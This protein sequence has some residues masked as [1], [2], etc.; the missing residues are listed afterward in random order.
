MTT[1]YP[2]V[3]P[4]TQPF[5]FSPTLDGDIFTA[6]VTWSLFGRRFYLNVYAADGTLIF[7]LPLIGSPSGVA[8]QSASFDHGR[9]T[10][11]TASPHGY[12]L[13]DTINL[14]ISGTTPDEYNGTVQALITGRNTFSFLS[15]V[16]L[17]S[18]S[19]LGVV[20]FNI[21]LAAGYF[22]ASTLVYREANRYFEVT[23]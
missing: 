16:D 14:T 12:L 3:Q 10:V 2:F 23:P 13:G 17:G 4:P 21:N 9:I 6:V 8:M 5:S 1:T 18:P 7:A 15:P 19:I 11:V 20:S 22:N